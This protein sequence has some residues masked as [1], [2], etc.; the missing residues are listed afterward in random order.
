MKSMFCVLMLSFC[1]CIQ[2][3]CEYSRVEYNNSTKQVYIQSKP[4]TLDVYETPF[5][6]RIILVTFI[7]IGN[8]YTLEIEITTDS[9]AQDLEPICFENGTR[10]SFSL[11]NND[12]ASITQTEEKIC[13]VKFFDEKTGYTTVSN[14]ARFLLTQEAY[15]KLIES[16]IVLMKI[17]S[18]TYQKTFV[19]KDEIEETFE[20][21]IKVT[22]PSRFFIDNIECMTKPKFK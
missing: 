4:I 5:N 14:Y 6:G 15:D 22:N 16:E 13:G 10:L 18:E 21:E 7:R 12:I 3:Q 2:G 8:Q 17:A 11:K 19:L 20:E 1:L 9:S